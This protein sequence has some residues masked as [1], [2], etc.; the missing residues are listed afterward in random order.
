MYVQWVLILMEHQ[1]VYLAIVQWLDVL[2][3]RHPLYAQYVPLLTTSPLEVPL[4]QRARLI[5][6]NAMTQDA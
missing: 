5:V 6:S 4:V 2:S 1:L 3:V